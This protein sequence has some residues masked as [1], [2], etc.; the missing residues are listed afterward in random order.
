[1]GRPAFLTAGEEAQ[2]HALIKDLRV[3]G[4]TINKTAVQFLGQ[5]VL[6]ASRPEGAVLPELHS[7]WARSYKKRWKLTNRRRATTDRKVESPAEVLMDNEWRQDL[8]DILDE[9]DRFGINMPIQGRSMSV[10]FVS[11][12]YFFLCHGI[13]KYDG[14]EC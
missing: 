10:L 11:P 13:V 9:P 7:Q 3:E 12:I 4:A 2:L 8:L 6:L 14:A 1:M 5:E